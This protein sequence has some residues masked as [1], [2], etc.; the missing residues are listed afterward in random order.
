MAKTTRKINSDYTNQISN[1]HK[2]AIDNIIFLKKQQWRATYYSV[3]L[4]AAIYAIAATN[5][6]IAP[7]ERAGLLVAICLMVLASLVLL[8]RM[9]GSLHKYRIRLSWLYQN[10]FSAEQ[11]E[12]LKLDKNPKSK[13]YDWEFVLSL[14]FVCIISGLFSGYLLLRL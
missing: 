6:P 10:F 7:N 9:Q 14:L 8:Y 13:W 4:V 11:R 5:K 2:D 12:A 1:L 3:L